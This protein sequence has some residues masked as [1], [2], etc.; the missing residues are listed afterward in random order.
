MGRAQSTLQSRLEQE[1][2]IEQAVGAWTSQHERWALMRLLQSHGIA[3][4]VVESIADNLTEDPWLGHHFVERSRPGDEVAFATHSQ[5]I[6]FGGRTP[7]V[8]ASPLWGEHNAEVLVGELG[9]PEAELAELVEQRV[10]F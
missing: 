3:A 2:S 7:Q 10:V 6:R 4:S 5:P 1:D 9:V 8:R